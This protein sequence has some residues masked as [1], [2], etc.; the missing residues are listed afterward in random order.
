[1]PFSDSS[2]DVVYCN[3]VIEHLGNYDDQA[4]LAREVRRVGSG[5]WVQTPAKRFPVEPHYLTPFAHWLPSA[6]SATHLLPYTVWAVIPIRLLT[7][8]TAKW[9]KRI[10]LVSR[11][12]LEKLFPGCSHSARALSRRDKVVVGG[13]T[14]RRY[15]GTMTHVAAPNCE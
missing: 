14:F 8:W 12:E 13:P 10:R 3:S 1:M 15:G 11:R 5:Y 2:F 4:K 9:L 7:T 6:D